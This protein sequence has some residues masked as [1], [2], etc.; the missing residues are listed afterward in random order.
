MKFI[1]TIPKAKN[2]AIAW[3]TNLRVLA[4][5]AVI[6]LHTG[7]PLLSQYNRLSLS[8]C[9]AGY[10]YNA[11]TRFAVPVFLMITGALLL[12]REY[13][14]TDFLKKRMSRLVP[15]FLFWSLVYIIYQWHEGATYFNSDIR[16]NIE[17]ILRRLKSG[18][19]YHLWYVYMLIGLYLIIPIISKFVRN[20]SEK[21]LLYFLA[22]WL[23][24]IILSE[25]Y[26]NRLNGTI[27]LRYFSG[28]IGYLV[29][30]YYLANKQFKAHGLIA[31][32]TFLFICFT[33]VITLGT[34][35]LMVTTKELSTVFY[36]PLGLCAL[37]LSASAFFIAK[38]IVV[39]LSFRITIIF[40]NVSKYT[41]GIYFIHALIL[42]VLAVNNITYAIFNPWLSIPVIALLCFVISWMLIY[43]MSK[44][45]VLKYLVG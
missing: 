5:F 4:T 20:A 35:Y 28:Y 15:A 44:L 8:D 17:Q 19:F 22:I 29:L 24:T 36:E 11:I 32:A 7:V 34:Y 6:V 23:I 3:I 14:S 33:M 18:T 31:F 1:E 16:G 40:E 37:I 21:E 13:E 2:Q 9:M 10:T 38:N 26:F 12:G 39:R 45:P 30:G 27:E 41:L 43:V 25:P 42:N